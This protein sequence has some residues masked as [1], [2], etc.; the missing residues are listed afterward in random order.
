MK[1]ASIIQNGMH[2]SIKFDVG[3]LN[4]ASSSTSTQFPKWVHLQFTHSPNLSF[5]SAVCRNRWPRKL[6]IVRSKGVEQ[7]EFSSS[8]RET[9]SS[10]SY[11]DNAESKSHLII[12][13]D[14]EEK[15]KDLITYKTSARTVALCVLSAVA[16]GV[17]LGLKDGIG[18]ASEFFA[19]Y[20]LEQSLSVDNLFVFVLVFKYFKVPL[21]Y[22]NRVL[23]FGIAGAIVFRLSLILL[24]TATLQRFEA[25]NLLLA[26]ILLYSSFK[27]FSA[28][29]DDEEDLS[30]N[31]IVKT[32]QK[33]I[34]VT[35]A[36]DGNRFFTV[37]NGAWKAT[38]LLL[39]VAVIELSD[40]AFAVDSIPAVFGV[41]RDPFVVFS[42]NLFA[43]LGLRS[44]Y[45]L[46]SEGMADLEYLQPSIGIVL[47]FIGCKMILDFF[48]YHV[49][50]E[51]SLGCVATTLSA[52]VLLSLLKKS[53]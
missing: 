43:I 19:G 50:T 33:I 53:D 26:S 31:F 3:L 22:Q 15:T 28:G 34:P 2:P 42:S 17:G 1:L 40:I 11:I 29:D 32:C 37:E 23:S 4:F 7:E 25:V 38:P 5:D 47:G 36:Y 24:G 16:F 41:T 48:G 20:L 49:S 6:S 21:A 9:S 8:E 12:D 13:N 44:L 46:I 51:V 45:T 52:G 35:S 27:L 18:K 14:S 30:D 39:T 10:N